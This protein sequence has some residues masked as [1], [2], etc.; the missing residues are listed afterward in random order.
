MARL[1]VPEQQRAAL[2]KVR[3]LPEAVVQQLATALG[4]IPPSAKKAEAVRAVSP[5]VPDMEACDLEGILAL[6]AQ[7]AD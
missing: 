4:S 2:V 3:A 5:H 7:L 1:N 6:L